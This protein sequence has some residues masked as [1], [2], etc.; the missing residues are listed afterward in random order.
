[1]VSGASQPLTMLLV[2]QLHL[3]QHVFAHLE[4]RGAGL[5]TAAQDQAVL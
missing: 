3:F 4:K 1:M 2:E 5:L